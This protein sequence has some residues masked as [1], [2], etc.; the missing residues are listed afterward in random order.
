MFTGLV[1][2]LGR[3]MQVTTHAQGRQLSIE[4]TLSLADRALGAS[5]AVRGVCLTVTSAQADRFSAFAAF[6][7]LSAS[8]L[9]ELGV[10][11]RV[12]LE[13]ALRVG[14]PLGGHLVG[15]HVD[16]VGLLREIRKRGA[17]QE[18]HFSAP[19]E[20]LRMVAVKGSIAVDGVSLTV[21]AVG[22]AT[23][24]VGVIPHTLQETTLAGISPG[25]RV[26]LEVD[27]IARYVARLQ[28]S[29]GSAP[30]VSLSTLVTAGF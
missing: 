23:F 28:E 7:T 26:N 21:N 8:T 12:N 1:Q 25:A 14:D 4:S 15:G 30:G 2:C 11:D 10:G 29:A 9:G 3:V 24:C 18:M 6:E 16:G 13:A 17:A 20:L 27:M 19:A 22:D 5:I